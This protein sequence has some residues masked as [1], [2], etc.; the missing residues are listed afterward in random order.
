MQ[1]RSTR[2]APHVTRLTY[3]LKVASQQIRA[4]MYKAHL[5]PFI[6]SSSS[7]PL[8]SSLPPSPKPLKVGTTRVLFDRPQGAL[9]ALTSLGDDYA[10]KKP[11]QQKESV[12]VAIGNAVKAI[13]GLG[14]TPVEAEVNVGAVDNSSHVDAHAAG[15]TFF[16]SCFLPSFSN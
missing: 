8:L 5:T 9:T 6:P 4:I 2:K 14:D 11:N 15:V 12:R 16:T 13:K 1:Q 3:M 7:H 10:K